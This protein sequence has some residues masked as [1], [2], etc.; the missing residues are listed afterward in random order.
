MVLIGDAHQLPPVVKRDEN[1]ILSQFYESPF[2]FSSRAF[3]ELNPVHI[4]LKKIYRQK[5][6]QFIDLLN[7]VRENRL[8]AGDLHLINTKYDPQFN[9]YNEG[10][11]T[12]STKRD[13]AARINQEH[14]EHLDGKLFT[15]NAEWEGNFPIGNRPADDE[16]HLKEGAQVMFVK[17]DSGE[18]KEYYNGKIGKIKKLKDETIIVEDENGLEIEV[19]QTSWENISY[20]YNRETKRMEEVLEGSFKQFPI[21]LAWAITVHKSQGLT[22]DKVVLDVG[23]SFLSGQVYV[24]MSRCTSLDSIVLKTKITPFAIK[25]N[26][27][28]E[29]FSQS[30]TSNE[31]LID[32]LN[33]GRADQHYSNAIKAF[34]KRDFDLAFDEFKNG[35]E[36]KNELQKEQTKRLFLLEM[37]RIVSGVDVN[38]QKIK[39]EANKD[40]N[41]ISDLIELYLAADDLSDKDRKQ[42]AIMVYCRILELERDQL[43]A[44]KNRA[45]LYYEIRDFSKAV[46]DYDRA[47]EID[48]NDTEL[49]HERANSLFQIDGGE[50]ESLD[51]YNK[52]ISIDPSNIRAYNNRGRTLR[53]LNR[54]EEAQNDFDYVIEQTTKELAFSSRKDTLYFYRGW[55]KMINE[56]YNE[57]IDDFNRA[58]EINPIYDR[59]LENRAWAKMGIKDYKGAIDDY[60]LFLKNETI[61]DDVLFKRGNARINIE[62]L[63]GAIK[64]YSLALTYNLNCMY[65]NNRGIA[66]ERKGDLEGALEDFR[67]ALEMKQNDEL[68]QRNYKRIEEELKNKTDDDLPF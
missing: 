48:P 34:K 38:S 59:A 4:V 28:I 2:F 60:T 26:I 57:A 50:I 51:D 37:K 30:I 13:R 6:Q 62:D 20:T 45:K 8:S 66:K 31:N 53:V 1:E 10:F 68:Y 52:S 23:D 43:K 49:Y 64:D 17:N 9:G 19:E 39:T 16:L 24:A 61:N 65:Y 44:L 36:L 56:A 25:S 11:I 67:V 47:I 35:M 63:D 41:N 29:E 18:F 33:S 32:E 55:A 46:D 14:L 42:E 3:A 40:Y 15:F 21:K 7:K 5:D 54:T 12:L 22:F 27:H 58:L